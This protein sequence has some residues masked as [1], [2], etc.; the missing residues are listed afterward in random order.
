MR[1]TSSLGLA[2]LLA[3][4]IW[5]PGVMMQRPKVKGK[6]VWPLPSKSMPRFVPRGIDFDTLVC[7]KA[8]PKQTALGTHA[9]L[10]AE[11][12]S[13]HRMAPP[14]SSVGSCEVRKGMLVL[15]HA[16]LHNSTFYLRT[17]ADA[18]RLVVRSPRWGPWG[19]LGRAE[20]PVHLQ[21]YGEA[22]PYGPPEGRVWLR[23]AWLFAQP[24]LAFSPKNVY[25]G[26]DEIEQLDDKARRADYRLRA[27]AAVVTLNRRGPLLNGTLLGAVIALAGDATVAY[28]LPPEPMPVPLCFR[29][30]VLELDQN[31]TRAAAACAAAVSAPGAEPLPRAPPGTRDS[32]VDVASGAYARLQMQGAP[33]RSSR[34][35]ASA[36]VLII[37]R[38]NQR[39]LVNLPFLAYEL[40]RAGA[41]VT[42]AAFEC[43]E[44][45]VQI[46]LVSRASTLIGAHGAA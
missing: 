46:A 42:I 24:R 31:E 29:T 23:G 33:P 1:S 30:A 6:V 13:A 38:L 21:T 7:P 18:E 43:L 10:T 5:D 17:G 20:P 9:P 37:H 4:A 36:R 25:H 45:T 8:P 3:P 41:H 14:L 34:G 11:S 44:L 19:A 16:C 39:R 12:A 35:F 32:F 15:R 40:L 26:L 27:F 2:L 22:V 28:H